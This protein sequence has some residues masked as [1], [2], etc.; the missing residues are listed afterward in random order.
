MIGE[1]PGHRGCRWSGIP[2]TDEI[3]LI[4]AENIQNIPLQGDEYIVISEKPHREPSASILWSVFE[5]ILYF[6]LLWNIFPF[7]P[8]PAGNFNKNRTPTQ[9]EIESYSYFVNDLLNLF[10]S[11][12]KVYA[13][14]RKSEKKFDEMGI[15]A[16]YIRHPANGG[17]NKCKMK[18]EEISGNM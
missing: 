13:L 16:E 4:Q 1:A 17:A 7:H 14:G 10:P 8:H 6:P 18:I 9:R 5:E 15:R 2:F 11:I 3:R 12:I